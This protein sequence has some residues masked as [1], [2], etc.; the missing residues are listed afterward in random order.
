MRELDCWLL[1]NRYFVDIGRDLF[2]HLLPL[3]SRVDMN[4]IHL[5]LRPLPLAAVLINESE[6]PHHILIHINSVS[7]NAD[8]MCRFICIRVE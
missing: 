7:G 3:G 8:C 4:I 1:L 2:F 6:S 5:P